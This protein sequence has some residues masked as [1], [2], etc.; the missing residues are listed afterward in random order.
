M[1]CKANQALAD[2]V[3]HNKSQEVKSSRWH[4][5]TLNQIITRHLVPPHQQVPPRHG[6]GYLLA[7]QLGKEINDIIKL[8]M[9][10]F[11]N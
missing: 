3:T 1:V 2:G 8:V 9:N 4:I 6:V 7:D 11:E 5:N 10:S